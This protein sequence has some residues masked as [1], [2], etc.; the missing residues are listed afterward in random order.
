MENEIHYGLP[1]PS[2]KIRRRL[3]NITLAFC[4]IVIAYLAYADGNSSVR[5]IIALGLIGLA[6]STLGSYL[7]GAVWDDKNYL[8]AMNEAQGKKKKGKSPEID[9]YDLPPR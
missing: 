4:A 2:W 8:N 6:G 9:E 1:K 7:F 3:V 5:E